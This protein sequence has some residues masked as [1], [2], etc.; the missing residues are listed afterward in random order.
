MEFCSANKKKPSNKKQ[1]DSLKVKWLFA[2]KK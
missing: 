2:I 1:N